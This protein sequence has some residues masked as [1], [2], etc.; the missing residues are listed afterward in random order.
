MSETFAR[1]W[2]TVDLW[3]TALVA[4]VA[5]AASHPALA[6]PWRILFD[7][8]EWPLDGHPASFDRAER[9]MSAVIG[10]V[11]LGWVALM[12]EVVALP[13]PRYDLVWRSAL[14]WFCFDS[15]GSVMSGV[16]GN[17]ILNSMFLLMFWAPLRTL[18]RPSTTR[19]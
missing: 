6:E 10:G 5:V 19:H 17:V 9:V 13:D 4:L 16:Y 2:L 14:V 1:R 11:M 12:R 3:I 18:R 15:A 8:L 7:L